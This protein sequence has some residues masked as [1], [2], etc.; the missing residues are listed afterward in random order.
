ME[1]PRS[2]FSRIIPRS[3]SVRR[4]GSSGWNPQL[5]SRAVLGPVRSVCRTVPAPVD[6]A[7]DGPARRPRIPSPGSWTPYS[8]WAVG[9]TAS[10][11]SLVMAADAPK[12]KAQFTEP[13]KGAIVL[14]DGKDASAWVRADGKPCP[15]LVKDGALICRPLTGNV[16]TK[17]TFG[18]HKLHI[19]FWT[20]LMPRAK[21]Q[22]RGNSGVFLHGRYEVQVL[23]SYGIDPPRKDDCGALYDM[24]APSVNACLPP[25]EWQS[26]DITFHAPKFDKDGQMTRRGRIT[27]VHNGITVIDDQEIPKSRRHGESLKPGP[28]MLQ[29]HLCP[30]AFRNIWVLPLAPPE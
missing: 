22:D 15:W 20:P 4:P 27:V 16:R 13:P 29:D 3:C 25:R 12:P 19:E 1:Y 17:Q 14:F 21:G 28:V 30:V 6:R 7:E 24:I 18:D 5:P 26:F 2:C 23:D 11:S 8:G 10:L 9:L